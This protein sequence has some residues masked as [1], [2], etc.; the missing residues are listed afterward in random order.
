MGIFFAVVCAVGCFI[1]FSI[2]KIYDV[3]T[4]HMFELMSLVM[5]INVFCVGLALLVAKEKQ[6]KPSGKKKGAPFLVGM[7]QACHG[8]PTAFYI[9]LFVHAMVWMGNTVWGAYG[10]E[11]FAHSVYPGDAE[12]PLKS[13]AREMYVEGQNAFSTAGQIGSGFNLLLSFAFMG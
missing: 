12:A 8:M 5:L 7:G 3:A 11:W 13:F 10:Q 2:M 6:F 4:H 1:A 9:L